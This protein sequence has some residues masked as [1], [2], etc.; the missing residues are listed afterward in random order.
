MDKFKIAFKDG[1]NIG[2]IVAGYPSIKY[3]KEF[4]RYTVLHEF[5]HLKYKTHSKKFWEMVERYMPYYE[6]YEYISNVA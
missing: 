1:A 2:Y 5:C 6:E 3:S 4:L